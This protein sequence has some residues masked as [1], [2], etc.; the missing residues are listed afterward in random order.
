[1]TV[2]GAFI[3]L[4]RASRSIGA[5]A[6]QAGHELAVGMLG[7]VPRA[8][9]HD[10]SVLRGVLADLR[11]HPEAF[12][13]ASDTA[14][15]ARLLESAIGDIS[16]AIEA[17]TGA[18]TTAGKKS[19]GIH[20]ATVMTDDGVSATERMHRAS[21]ALRDAEARLG[22]RR[23]LPAYEAGP[24]PDRSAMLIADAHAPEVVGRGHRTGQRIAR[25]ILH[26]GLGRLLG[27]RTVN[28]STLP[29]QGA[30]I[31][32]PNHVSLMD[33]IHALAVVD[34]PLR[35]M[36]KAG[37]FK[38]KALGSVLSLA[39]AYPVKHGASDS[40]LA[41][42][43]AILANDEALLVYP[44][45][46]LLHA[47]GPGAHGTGVAQLA[48]ELG[49]SVTPLGTWGAGPKLLRASEGKLPRRPMVSAAFGE[50]IAA[51]SS[52]TAFNQAIFR[53]RIARAQDELVETA[54]AHH[55][56]RVERAR[57]RAPFVM[58]GVAAAAV[59]GAVLG[60]TTVHD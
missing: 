44:H 49:A 42:A 53:E 55:G 11:A 37:L 43:R 19:P 2:A 8:L 20:L 56:E 32:A 54:R 27:V 41:N 52:P 4:G 60:A 40:A 1:M 18:L 51:P 36:A 6:A 48:S 26:G 13:G 57:Q 24:P 35:P 22:G 12:V 7:N 15:G 39:G 33:P 14:A 30:T 25:G 34:R 38:N 47:N 10:R 3:D 29:A 16:G 28:A 5:V 31:L 46:K 9:A 59:G 21:S 58:G 23:A 50:P 17:A 45:G